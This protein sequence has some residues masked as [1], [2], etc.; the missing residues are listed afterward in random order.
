ML[1]SLETGDGAGDGD[2]DGGRGGNGNG[3]GGDDADA[4][5][6]TRADF[7]SDALAAPSDCNAAPSPRRPPLDATRRMPQGTIKRSPLEGTLE[8]SIVVSNSRDRVIAVVRDN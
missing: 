8:L 5:A 6:S 3:D 1:S 2:G 4:D 7:D